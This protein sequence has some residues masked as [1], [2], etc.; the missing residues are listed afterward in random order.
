[1]FTLIK[2]FKAKNMDLLKTSKIISEARKNKNMTQKELAEK[3]YNYYN[4]EE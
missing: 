3:I 1:M 2:K 4:G